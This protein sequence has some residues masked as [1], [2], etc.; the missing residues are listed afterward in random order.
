MTP[1][2]L[3]GIVYSFIAAILWGINGVIVKI[4]LKDIHPFHGTFI[5]ILLSIFFLLPMMYATGS[6][7][8]SGISHRSLIFL[9]IAGLTQYFL[10][11]GFSFSAVKYIGPSRAYS[12]ISMRIILS[13]LFGVMILKEVMTKS[14]AF[15]TFLVFTGIYFT[16]TDKSGVINRKGVT[17]ALFS[18]LSRGVSP[19]FIKLG[20]IA[21]NVLLSNLISLISASVAFSLGTAVYGKVKIDRR[22]A[23]YMVV[24][25]AVTLSAVIFY[26]MALSITPVTIVAPITNLSLFITVVT[27]YL[28]IQ[29]I[30]KINIKIVIGA[31]LIVIGYYFVVK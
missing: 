6:F 18:T 11:R 8:I 12:I 28:I 3:E 30:E 29:K 24:S 23:I 14:L 19:I 9:A 16:L 1:S 7:T 25:S 13:A 31:F 20:L 21:G 2:Y 4:G 5:T 17:Y 15:G 26:Y 27:S 22:S 10:G